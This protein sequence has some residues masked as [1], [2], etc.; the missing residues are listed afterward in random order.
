[1]KVTIL[2]AGGV[3]TPFIVRS[4]II[5]QERLGRVILLAPRLC[6]IECSRRLES[7]G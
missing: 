2:G 1:M 3:R 7:E 5:R 4:F 6:P